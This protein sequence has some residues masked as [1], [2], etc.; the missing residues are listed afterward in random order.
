MKLFLGVDGGQSSTTALIG[1]ES[2]RVIGVGRAGPVN[3]VE[4]PEGPEKFLHAMEQCLYAAGEAGKHFAS[5]CF[6]F[7]GGPEDKETLTRNIVRSDIY[8]ITH[9]AEIALA[10]ATAGKPGV[11]VIA[12]TGSMAFGKDPEGQTARAGG[13][14]YIF[15]DEGGAFDIVRQ[16]LRAVV[17]YEE[18]WGDP[19]ALREALLAA[20]GAN[21]ANDLLHK[22]YTKDWPR[23]R[24]AALAQTV[25]HAVTEGDETARQILGSAAH[26]LAILAQS[27][28]RKLF[29]EHLPATISY[30]GGVFR[31]RAILERFRLLVE[32]EDGNH[33][34]A[35][36]YGPAAG[37]LI[38]AY[39][40]AGVECTLKDVPEEK[41]ASE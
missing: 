30:V 15:G 5:A 31:S 13:W 28:R 14:G 6:G 40:A 19:T 20:T 37:A 22:F 32:L 26:A 41:I 39:R 17:R 11:V 27:V 34:A 4:G 38:E 29:P 1:D 7:S 35:P 23:H 36:L 21:S 3:H 2:G 25:E 8:R 16:A 24:V 9:D 12:G 18:G 33:V 10:G